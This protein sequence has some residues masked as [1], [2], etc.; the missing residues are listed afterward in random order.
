MSFNELMCVLLKDILSVLL[1]AHL[2]KVSGLL[3]LYSMHQCASFEI[4]NVTHW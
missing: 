4:S 3:Y 1:S 2:E